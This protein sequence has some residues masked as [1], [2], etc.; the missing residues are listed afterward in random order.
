MD[1]EGFMTTSLNVDFVREQFPLLKD[2]WVFL[3][4]AGGSY[5]PRQVIERTTEYMTDSQVQPN[6]G[7]ASSERATARIKRGLETAAEFINAEVDEVFL[8]PSTTMNVFVMS[9]ALAAGFKRGDEIIVTEQD[10]EANIGAWRRLAAQGLTIREWPVD[11]STGVLIP[12]ALERLLNERTKIVAFTHCSNVCSIVH[13]LPKLIRK[14]HGVGALAFVDGTAYAPHFPIDVK[15]LEVDFYVFSLYKVCGPHQSVLYGRRALLERA[16][17]LNHFFIGNESI[18]Y[19]FLPGGPNHEMAAATVGLGEYFDALYHAHFNAPE[20]AFHTR[21]H[22]VYQLIGAHEAQ[23]ASRVERFLRSRSEVRV[24]GRVPSRDGRLAPVISFWIPGRKSTEIAAALQAQKIAIGNGD[25]WAR[26][27]VSAVGLNPD[28]GV[29]R[30]GI[31]H[32]NSDADID[33][34]LEAL[35]RVLP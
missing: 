25:F 8:G 20:N 13:D 27:C 21:L 31:A 26:R 29:V 9:Q 33:R 23:L 4:N 2:G 16:A 19:K 6:W 22:Q 34:L 15:A 7:F 30:V 3:E 1:G 10:H 18:T 24:L 5:V 28:D 12:D 17:G 14:I 32:Y 11:R 35:Q